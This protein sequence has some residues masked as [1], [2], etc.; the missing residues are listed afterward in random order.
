ML[1]TKEVVSLEEHPTGSAS[2]SSEGGI[3]GSQGPK[4]IAAVRRRLP[5]E[6]RSLTHH[7][8]IAGQEGYVTVGL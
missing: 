8:S 1:E 6:R 7:F 5:G 4:A 2:P 3:N